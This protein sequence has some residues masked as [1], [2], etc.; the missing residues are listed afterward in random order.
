ML[1]CKILRKLFR[2]WRPLVTNLRTS[3]NLN[4]LSLKELIGILKMH[5]LELQQ[6]KMLRNEKN[7]TLKAQQPLRRTPT[8]AFKV[9]EPF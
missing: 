9:E 6:D 8:K 7:I 5:E 2:Q 4:G 3:K 1:V